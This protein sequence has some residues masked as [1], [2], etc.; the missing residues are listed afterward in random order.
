MNYKAM[1]GSPLTAERLRHAFDYNP[2]TGVF[3]RKSRGI[4]S[5]TGSV[6]KRQNT[7][8]L[9]IHIGGKK[10]SAHR[11][12]WLYH[13]GTWPS[14]VIDHINGDG[15]DNRIENLRDV[16][17]QAN[18]KNQSLS[19]RNKSGVLGVWLHPEEK[20]WT[21]Y[22]CVKGKKKYLYWGEDF[23]EA[24]CRRK[25]AE[26]KH[27]YHENHGRPGLCLHMR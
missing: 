23:F 15:L 22:I 7:S 5:K 13:Y 11:L 18:Q 16:D 10:Y 27:D 14:N 8:Y 2:E 12:S 26:N 21:T 6:V 17:S 1:D 20:R 4:R 25:S 3:K 9:A 19:S 24:C